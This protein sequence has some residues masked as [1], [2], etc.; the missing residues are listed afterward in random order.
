MRQRAERVLVL[1]CDKL[2]DA[3]DQAI[4][5]GQRTSNARDVSGAAQKYWLAERDAREEALYAMEN[6]D[7]EN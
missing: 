1:V 7:G 6:L 4:V 3:A 2:P 5:D